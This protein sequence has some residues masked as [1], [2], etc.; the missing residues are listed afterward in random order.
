MGRMAG[1]GYGGWS[2]RDGVITTNLDGLSIH[3]FMAFYT[4]SKINDKREGS[5]GVGIG[6]RQVLH[7]D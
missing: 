2:S 3:S 7:I 5:H 4:S 1:A 6:L